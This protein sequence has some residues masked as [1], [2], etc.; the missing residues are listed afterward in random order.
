MGR[1]HRELR[2]ERSEVERT[3]ERPTNRLNRLLEEENLRDLT[4]DGGR[5]GEKHSGIPSLN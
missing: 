5:V 4:W 3:G 1:S 2:R